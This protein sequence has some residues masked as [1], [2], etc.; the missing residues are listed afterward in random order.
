MI[1]TDVEAVVH[2]CRLFLPGMVE[3]DR[4]GPQRRVDRRVSNRCRGQAGYSASKA[5]VLSYSQA[6]GASWRRAR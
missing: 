2:L 6:A 5:F 3:R 1:R 4:R